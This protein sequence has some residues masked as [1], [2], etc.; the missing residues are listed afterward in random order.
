MTD[1]FDKYLIVILKLYILDI[2]TFIYFYPQASKMENG[3]I[4]LSNLW[5]L[6][7]HT[8]LALYDV[9]KL[10][11]LKSFKSVKILIKQIIFNKI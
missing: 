9:R 5:F 6:K 3:C 10:Y 11:G 1:T 7:A 8:I 4:H 2:R